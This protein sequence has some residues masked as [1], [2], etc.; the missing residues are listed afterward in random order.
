VGTFDLMDE[1]VGAAERRVLR[2]EHLGR[3]LEKVNRAMERL[4]E[5]FGVRWLAYNPIRFYRWHLFAQDTKASVAESILTAFPKA[6]SF[7]DV[8]AGTGTYA[9]ELRRR[10]VRTVACE[11]SVFGRAFSYYQRLPS[12]PFDLGRQE[13]ARLPLTDVAY[14]FEVGEHL[15][16]ELGDRLVAYLARFPSVLFTA[17]HPGQGGDDH[18]NEQPKAYWIERFARNGMELDPERTDRIVAA[19]RASDSPWWLIDN[20]MVFRRASSTRAATRAPAGSG[21]IRA[22]RPGFG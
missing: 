18:I 6:R 7:A 17:A 22:G 1:R 19:F 11:N 3:G 9:A 5:R 12:R 16:H 15:P 20:A 13:P 10:G 21:S 4:G 14:C 2:G 8:G